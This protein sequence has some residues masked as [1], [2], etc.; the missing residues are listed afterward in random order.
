MPHSARASD[1]N[2]APPSSFT[3]ARTRSI[4]RDARPLAMCTFRSSSRPTTRKRRIARFSTHRAMRALRPISPTMA[5]RVHASASA[6]RERAEAGR[7]QGVRGLALEN[8]E[9]RLATGPIRPCSRGRLNYGS[10]RYPEEEGLALGA[11]SPTGRLL[12]CRDL[13]DALH[14]TLGLEPRKQPAEKAFLR[15]GLNL[16]LGQGSRGQADGTGKSCASE[17]GFQMRVAGHCKGP[18]APDCTSKP[19]LRTNCVPHQ[20]VP[21]NELTTGNYCQAKSIG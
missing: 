21:R 15:L 10:E 13:S 8:L 3:R 6:P 5:I 19:H 18:P 17:N 7:L 4:G 14:R 1:R 2:R 16:R 12:A 9:R 11:R 20:K